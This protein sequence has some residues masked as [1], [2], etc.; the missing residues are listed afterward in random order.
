MAD[1]ASKTDDSTVRLLARQ[2]LATLPR[3]GG[4]GD[5]IRMGILHLMRANGIKEG[6]R[7][8]IEDR[9][10]EE[11]HQKLHTNT[12][13]D[14]VAICEAYLH[15]LHT[16]NW[17]DFYSHIW[18]NHGIT[19]E[20]RARCAEQTTRICIPPFAS[21]RCPC[22]SSPA[23]NHA[24]PRPPCACH[25]RPAPSDSILVSVPR[26]SARPLVPARLATMDHPIK[27]SACHL[28]H[29]IGPMKHFL[30]VLKI[31]HSGANLDTAMEFSKVP[32][33]R[34]SPHRVFWDFYALINS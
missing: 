20:R 1:V 19:R 9:F 5:D 3:G 4:N 21:A 6:H 7:P 11:W 30:W 22:G 26:L 33:D 13:F 18:E 12:T 29:L 15:F 28:P 10:L 14:D 31:T 27:S 24:M 17:D 25:R 34:P 23:R 16:G 2:S 8:G 32:R